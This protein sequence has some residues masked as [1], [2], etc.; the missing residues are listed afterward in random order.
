VLQAGAEWRF[1]ALVTTD[2]RAAENHILSGEHGVLPPN[3]KHDL[4]GKYHQARIMPAWDNQ[5]RLR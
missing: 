2:L 5:E 1:A 3:F 4:T